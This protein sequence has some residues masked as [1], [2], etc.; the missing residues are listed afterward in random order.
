MQIER[1][2]VTNMVAAGGTAFV[3]LLS[4]MD[5]IETYLVG[6]PVIW[7]VGGSFVAACWAYEHFCRGKGG[8]DE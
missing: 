8:L 1:K 7:L 5:N 3:A 4:N 6:T 2:C